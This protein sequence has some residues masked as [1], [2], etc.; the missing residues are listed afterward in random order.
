MPIIDYDDGT[1][2]LDG[3]PAY[4]QGDTRRCGQACTASVLGYFGYHVTFDDLVEQTAGTA[5][6][7]GMSMEQIVWT[8]RKYGLQ[9]RSFTG[10]LQDLKT[11]INKG[12]PVIVAFDEGDI[13][14]VVVVI[15]YNDERELIFYNDSMD[16]C[17]MEEPYSDFIRAWSRRRANSSGFFDGSVANMLIQVSR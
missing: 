12:N 11:Q 16:G 2:I 14:H 9:A 8:L 6:A 15:G 13:Q 5:G 3:I 7:L 17:T 4:Y 1:R 10:R